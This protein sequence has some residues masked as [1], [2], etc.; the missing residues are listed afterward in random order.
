MLKNL[1]FINKS[2]T[3][4]QIP[5]STYSTIDFLRSEKVDIDIANEIKENKI[6]VCHNLFFEINTIKDFYYFLNI[7]E[8]YKKCMS[9]SKIILF[10]F[11]PTLYKD[12]FLKE[13]L[14]D[15]VIL[16][17][18]EVTIL[19][20]IKKEKNIFDINNIYFLNEDCEVIKNNF[21]ENKFPEYK[22]STFE[23]VKVSSL[24]ENVTNED[25][26]NIKKCFKPHSGRQ[27]STLSK[28][29][30]FSWDLFYNGNKSE[31]SDEKEIFMPV[32]V[33]ENFNKE[34]YFYL[35]NLSKTSKLEFFLYEL[36]KI[37]EL[38]ETVDDFCICEKILNIDFKVNLNDFDKYKDHFD[39]IKIINY[40]KISCGIS[41]L[42]K[43]NEDIA[44]I[45]IL[46]RRNFL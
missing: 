23:F 2:N 46:N 32:V 39:F 1:F 26:F 43:V 3:F 15:V 22:N 5:F 41:S 42:Y 29:N 44:H 4:F 34:N 9:S 36:N 38:I 45:S 33:D 10:G 30:Y 19:E 20:L 6:K 27:I 12:S 17:D 37:E 24:K 21:V 13:H 14:A 11:L 8:V 25:F 7:L 31:V 28:N 40:N 18:P 16:C 35:K